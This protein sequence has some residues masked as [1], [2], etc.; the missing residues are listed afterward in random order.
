MASG[1]TFAH[2]R[3]TGRSLGFQWA[4]TPRRAP[5]SAPLAALLV[6][7]AS[8][9]APARSAEPQRTAEGDGGLRLFRQAPD[10]T[11]PPGTEGMVARPTDPA[12]RLAAFERPRAATT[13]APRLLPGVPDG[14]PVVG[15]SSTSEGVFHQFGFSTHGFQ[16]GPGTGAMMAELVAT[17]STNVPIDGLEIGRF[18]AQAARQS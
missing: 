9:A 2:R 6:L 4:S 16:L 13:A 15:R 11:L 14:I 17:G 10:F 5:R 18:A 1:T 7:V 8:C 3:G 12:R